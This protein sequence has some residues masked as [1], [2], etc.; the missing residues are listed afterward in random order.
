MTTITSNSF[1]TINCC[2]VT[3]PLTPPTAE[4]P[5]GRWTKLVGRLTSACIFKL[6]VV[7]GMVP[8]HVKRSVV[9]PILVGTDQRHILQTV[10]ICTLS[11]LRY[12]SHFHRIDVML[13][14]LSTISSAL[15]DNT[16]SLSL[17]LS[18]PL[19][20]LFFFSLFQRTSTFLTSSSNNT[21]C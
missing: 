3:A 18:C 12:P 8:F 19:V 7:A 21:L 2:F 4:E 13:P 5:L 1:H 6:C 20:S 17:L 10:L 15:E 14:F 11:R 16:S 9:F